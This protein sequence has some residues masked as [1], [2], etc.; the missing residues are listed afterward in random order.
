M[1]PFSYFDF[2]FVNDHFTLPSSNS[3]C[4][5]PHQNQNIILF[6][7]NE[8]S[9]HKTQTVEPNEVQSIPK[10][11]L[12]SN[13]EINRLVCWSFRFISV[14]SMASVYK[15]EGFRANEVK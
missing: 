1:R 6:A 11:A 13:R 4:E 7:M 12:T 3:F 10:L 14:H 8:I 15:A 2:Y 5:W 9:S